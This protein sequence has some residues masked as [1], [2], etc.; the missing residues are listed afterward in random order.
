MS[1][2]KRPFILMIIMHDQTTW[3][4][5]QEKKPRK[6]SA[7]KAP[8]VVARCSKG[9]KDPNCTCVICRKAVEQEVNFFRLRI[10]QHAAGAALCF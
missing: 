6:Q 5:K 4:R 3:Q 8:P 9:Q 1:G 10:S 7:P 2:P